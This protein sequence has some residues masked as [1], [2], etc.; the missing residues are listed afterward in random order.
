MTTCLNGGGSGK[1][2]GN[3]Y[4]SLVVDKF[5]TNGNGN[6]TLHYDEALAS[7]GADKPTGFVVK[8]TFE[9]SRL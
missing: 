8:S 6:L 2:G 5:S 4:G 1:G 9:D 7:I 3:F